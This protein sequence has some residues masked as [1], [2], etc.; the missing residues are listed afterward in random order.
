MA[1]R[2]KDKGR[3][4]SDAASRSAGGAE[5]RKQATGLR[6]LLAY[7]SVAARLLER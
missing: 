3:A 6:A 4:I 2:A 1:A 5:G 7:A